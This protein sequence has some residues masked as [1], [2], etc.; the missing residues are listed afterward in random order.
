MKHRNLMILL[1]LLFVSPFFAYGDSYWLYSARWEGSSVPSDSEL[2]SLAKEQGSL[3]YIEFGEDGILRRSI[4]QFGKLKVGY[5]GF[6]SLNRAL[7]EKFADKAEK[8]ETK[9]GGKHF[10]VQMNMATL[11]WT[12]FQPK[13]NE[14][15]CETKCYVKDNL[16]YIEKR[17]EVYSA[18][19]VRP[20]FIRCDYQRDGQQGVIVQVFEPYSGGKS[21][22]DTEY[23]AKGG[24]EEIIKVDVK[25]DLGKAVETQPVQFTAPLTGL[26]LSFDSGWWPNGKEGGFE[27]EPGGFPVQVRIRAAAVSNYQA[28]VQ[29]FFHLSPPWLTAGNASGFWGYDFGAELLMK[30]GFDL[31][32]IDP[33]TVD[34]PYVPDVNLRASKYDYFNSFLLDSTSILQDATPKTNLFNVDLVDV[35]LGLVGVTLPD[36][37]SWI[38][39]SAGAGI[40]A[41]TTTDG[42]LEC[43]TISLQE[44]LLLWEEGQTVPVEVGEDGYRTIMNYNEICSLVL[45]LNFYPT[46]FIEIFG[47][48]YSLPILTIPWAPYNGPL[49]LAFASYEANFTSGPPTQPATDWFTEDF[50]TDNDLDYHRLLLTPTN[51]ANQYIACTSQI[52]DYP[53]DSV[54]STTVNLGDDAYVEVPLADGKQVVL[55]GVAYDR[56]FIGSNGYLTFTEGDTTNGE[57]TETHFRIPRVSGMF[58]N[59]KPNDGG[60]IWWK[61]MDDRFVVTYN[62]VRVDGNFTS[63]TASFQIE[64]FFD[65]QIAISWLNVEAYD[66]LVGISAGNGV[67][68]NFKES[69]VTRYAL[70][71]EPEGVIEGIPEGSVEGEGIPE[72]TVEGSQEGTIEGSVEG[73]GEI[74]EECPQPCDIVSC[75]TTGVQGNARNSWETYCAM[76]GID[77]VT[78]DL[79]MNQMV[80]AAQLQLLDIILANPGIQNRCCV[81]AAWQ[82]NYA[83]FTNIIDSAVSQSLIPEAVLSQISAAQLKSLFAGIATIG[84]SATLGLLGQM[85]SQTGISFS[86]G[87]IDTSASQYLGVY[88]DSDGDRVCNLAEYNATFDGTSNSIITFVLSAIDP[89]AKSNGGGCGAPCFSETNEGEILPI[90]QLSV[91]T[92]GNTAPVSVQVS[93]ISSEDLDPGYYYQGTNITANVNYN[94]S[95]DVWQGWVINGEFAG[96]SNPISFS[97]IQNTTLK[98]LFVPVQ[99]EGSPDGEQPSVIP[100]IQ[101]YVLELGEVSAA[102]CKEGTFILTNSQLS[103]E[104]LIGNAI[105]SAPEMP[106]EAFQIISGA[107]Y[108]LNPGQSQDVVVK[109]CAEGVNPGEYLA[110]VSF[111]GGPNMLVYPVTV[112]VVLTEGEGTIEGSAEG[113]LEGEG[114]TEGS[115]EGTPEGEGTTEGT[116]EGEELP[117]HSAD[118]DMNWKIDLRELLRVIQFF[119]SWG[120][121]CAN[122]PTATE[123]GYEVGEGSNH[124]CKPHTSDYNPQ[125]WKIDLRELLRLIQF[126]NSGGYHIDATGEDGFG[127]GI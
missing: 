90:Y 61:Q 56:V 28:D 113:T 36:W 101:P 79:D 103:A 19:G 22:I 108:N 57:S 60:Q 31:G 20:T 33:F 43:D 96:L 91:M 58:D 106:S 50:G 63:D 115:V 5:P 97:I 47:L 16:L 27:E 18:N 112:T 78:S 70:C 99:P 76:K 8:M 86:T 10:R 72:G 111:T 40:D 73:E 105:I 89:T 120:Y 6:A 38:P 17:E 24:V 100:I 51:N 44:G 127:V 49:D 74:P 122:T 21:N 35:I 110:I 102:D 64:M 39:F 88:G 114:T 107:N 95:K 83:L 117:W 82:S 125:D 67:P 34:I 98:A 85:A 62:E 124:N 32:I 54:L 4:V 23:V 93:P 84:D 80:E 69:D 53:V 37:L 94:S 15:V 52:S 46:V 13:G 75:G 14:G 55:Y 65:G 11:E 42:S 2:V 30:A 126:F 109:F 3:E 29:G 121:H 1:L 81:L 25:G 116:P 87:Q 123:D 119:N 45:S 104:A 68:A 26:N 66:G 41:S 48:N 12:V 7:L 92:E 77:S 71:I 118:R 9:D 59:L